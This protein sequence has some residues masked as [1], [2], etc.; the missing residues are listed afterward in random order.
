MIDEHSFL[1]KYIN[2]NKDDDYEQKRKEAFEALT[3][4][5]IEFA[6]LRDKYV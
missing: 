3:H 5:E 1:S 4:I 6:R 2:G